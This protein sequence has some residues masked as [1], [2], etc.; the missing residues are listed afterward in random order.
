M[1]GITD[2]APQSKWQ[3][4][5]CVAVLDFAIASLP[6]LRS[7]V[8]NDELYCFVAMSLCAIVPSGTDPD[9]MFWPHDGFK[10]SINYCSL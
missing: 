9:P 3:R 8:A 10:I 4:Q 2:D 7:T 1:L 5:V 6:E